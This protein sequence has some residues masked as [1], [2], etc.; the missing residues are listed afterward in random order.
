MARHSIMLAF[1]FCITYNIVNGHKT[2]GVI[3]YS[4]VWK[5]HSETDSDYIHLYANTENIK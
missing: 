5:R 4:C 3:S 1:F 2:G